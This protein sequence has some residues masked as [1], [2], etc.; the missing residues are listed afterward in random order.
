MNSALMLIGCA[1]CRPAAGSL[2]AQAQDSAVIV[3]LAALG[4]VFCVV[5]YTM[6]SFARRQRRF[7]EADA[8][9]NSN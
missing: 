6:F 8:L 4:V 3:M 9:F 1:T 5:F 2:A 7:A